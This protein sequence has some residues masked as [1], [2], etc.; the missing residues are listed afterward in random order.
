MN[1][2]RFHS[3]NEFSLYWSQKRVKFTPQRMKFLHSID[4]VNYSLDFFFLESIN[5]RKLTSGTYIMDSIIQHY[6]RIPRL[7]FLKIC[8]RDLFSRCL[9]SEA[10]AH[11]A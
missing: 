4:G 2:T 1:R 3:F 11:F 7:I 10:P 9:F 6:D 5:S 8:F